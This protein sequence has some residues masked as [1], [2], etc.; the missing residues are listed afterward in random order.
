[1]DDVFRTTLFGRGFSALKVLMPIRI[2]SEKV[3]AFTTGPQINIPSQPV[4][5][6]N[7]YFKRE[8][9]LF[10]EFAPEGLNVDI[11]VSFIIGNFKA[12]LEKSNQQQRW[13]V[14]T[15]SGQ[16]GIGKT[17]SSFELVRRLASMI[18]GSKE[19]KTKRSKVLSFAFKKFIFSGFVEQV[20]SAA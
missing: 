17:R 14:L 7:R 3:M 18:R 20:A 8:T 4:D 5:M 11:I 19:Y 10:S 13:F 15:L 1:L 2:C 12:F 9:F 16:S 6:W